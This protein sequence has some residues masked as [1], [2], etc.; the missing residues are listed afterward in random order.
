MDCAPVSNLQDCRTLRVVYE[1]EDINFHL[2]HLTTYYP[3][4]EHLFPVLIC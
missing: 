2:F 3:Y 1:Y 4:L